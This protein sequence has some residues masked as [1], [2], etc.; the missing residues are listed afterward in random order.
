M[1]VEF[2]QEVS[3]RLTADNFGWL[4]TVAKSGQPVPRLV[5]FYFD[6]A[7]VIIYSEPDAAK[8]RHIKNHP[9]VSL[10][11]D[12]DGNGGGIIAVG[13]TATIDAQDVN[14]LEDERYQK[15][16]REYAAS[17]GFT[18]EFLAAYNTR[19]KISIDKVWTTPTGG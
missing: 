5:W 4:T 18:D 3:S 1:A 14:P 10:I 6:G 9:R 11:L 2:T 16:Y 8:V 13:G 17:V 7:D 19:L 12:S 15:K